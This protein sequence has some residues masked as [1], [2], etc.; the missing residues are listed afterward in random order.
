MFENS[1]IFIEVSLIKIIFFSRVLK[2][3][4]NFSQQVS[5]NNIKN[6]LSQSQQL[7][8]LSYLFFVV[9]SSTI[10]T[11]NF[12][13]WNIFSPEVCFIVPSICQ[14]IVNIRKISLTFLSKTTINTEPSSN[15]DFTN[16]WDIS[17]LIWLIYKREI[18]R[19][20]PE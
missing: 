6:L 1:K 5:C 8:G 16:A 18:F 9:T 12:S 15:Y 10:I 2:K 3:F 20:K 19:W 14:Y 11:W 17:N 13:Y 4:S 7:S